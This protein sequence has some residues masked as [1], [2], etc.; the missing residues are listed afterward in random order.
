LDLASLRAQ[1]MMIHLASVPI[2]KLA[3][4]LVTDFFGPRQFFCLS[5]LPFKKL[6]LALR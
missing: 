4:S 1:P 6:V 3:R 5:P 2:L